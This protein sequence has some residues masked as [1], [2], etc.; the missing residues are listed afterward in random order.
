MLGAVTTSERRQR[1]ARRV[2]LGVAGLLT[3]LCVGLLLAAIR[4]DQAISGHLGVTT[5]DVNAVSWDRAI[6]RFETPDGVVHIPANGVLYPSGLAAGDLVRVEYDTTNPELARVAGR[7]AV[8]TLL[9]LGSTVLVTWLV[10]GSLLWWMRHRARQQT[11]M[12][13]AALPG[14]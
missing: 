9:P 5:A 13:A 8:R 2:L 3:A 10:A 6:I 11:A 4:N 14:Q 1:F 7:T 12:A